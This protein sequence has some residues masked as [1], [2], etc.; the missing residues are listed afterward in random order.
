MYLLTGLFCM[1]R[2]QKYRGL[3]SFRSS[4]W[5]PLENLPPDFSRIYQFQNFERMRRRILAD[6]ASE[7]EGAMVCMGGKGV[8]GVLFFLLSSHEYLGFVPEMLV[9]HCLPKEF[10][11]E[12][13]L[14]F[15]QEGWYVTLHIVDVPPSVIES[16]QTGKPLVLVSLLPHEQKVLTAYR[17]FEYFL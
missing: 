2:F 4:P 13:H 8:K 3:K 11:L 1:F 15:L 7:E 5:D 12:I 16:F 9:F 14:L 6:A 10:Y 17:I